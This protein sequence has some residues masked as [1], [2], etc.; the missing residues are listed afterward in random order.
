MRPIAFKM[1]IGDIVNVP[2]EIRIDIE[3]RLDV[4]NR[5]FF[6][7]TYLLITFKAFVFTQSL[8]ERKQD[9]LAQAMTSGAKRHSQLI[10]SF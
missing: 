4:L 3:P 6:N 10:A 1:R 2:K 5:K 7:A 9:G 8:H